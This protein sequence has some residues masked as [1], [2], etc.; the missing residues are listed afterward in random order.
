MSLTTAA[1]IPATGRARSLHRGVEGERVRLRRDLRNGAHDR[2]DLG[3]GAREALGARRSRLRGRIAQRDDVGRLTD[4]VDRLGNRRTEPL[5]RRTHRGDVRHRILRNER[6]LDRLAFRHGGHTGELARGLI[7]GFDAVRHAEQH[8]AHDPVEAAD[9]V[10]E[11]LAPLLDAF[12]V[13]D[14]GAQPVAL[15][16]RALQHDDGA[17]DV[18]H[19]VDA[20]NAGHFGLP[21]AARDRAD[22]FGDLHQ[23][24]RDALRQQQHDAGEGEQRDDA[25]MISHRASERPSASPTRTS[26]LRSA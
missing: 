16:Q 21:V 4:T 13:R 14:V 23:R 6:R 20:V 11:R 9:R 26:S 3:R 2:V 12:G 18:A 25:A 10:F 8:G 17:R 7:H 5:G 19:L 15:L 1:E 22:R 24:P